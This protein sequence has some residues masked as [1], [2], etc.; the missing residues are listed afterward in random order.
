MS[1]PLRNGEISVQYTPSAFVSFV[2]E[3]NFREKVNDTCHENLAP[4]GT[5]QSTPRKL[6]WWKQQ[7]MEKQRIVRKIAKDKI[8]KKSEFFFLYWC[9]WVDCQVA[10]LLTD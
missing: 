8:A 5:R 2:A 10:F 4:E 3:V 1:D 6:Y 9:G 7:S